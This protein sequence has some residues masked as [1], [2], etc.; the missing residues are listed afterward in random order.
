MRPY[1]MDLFG[2]TKYENDARKPSGRTVT[3]SPI[4]SLQRHMTVKEVIRNHAQSESIK[5]VTEF[6]SA[7][8]L[9]FC[10]H[11]LKCEFLTTVHQVDINRQTIETALPLIAFE[12]YRETRSTGRNPLTVNV[13][14]GNVGREDDRVLN[15]DVV[16]AI[17]L[18]EHLVSEDFEKFP[19]TVF[20]FI[21]PKLAIVTTPNYDFNVLFEN[22][23]AFR[24]HDHKFEFTRKQFEDWARD[25]TEKYRY[26]VEIFG[27]GEPPS[28]R[29][30]VG[31]CSQMAVFKK[32]TTTTP[33]T[34]KNVRNY[35]LIGSYQY[36]YITDTRT[37]E[38]KI[39]DAINSVIARYGREDYELDIEN[40]CEFHHRSTAL[41]LN[42]FTKH[43]QEW[44]PDE[45]SL[46]KFLENYRVHYPVRRIEAHGFIV[47]LTNDCETYG[48]YS[49]E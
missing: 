43:C 35:N 48:C 46:L 41:P 12:R 11:L 49:T 39:L 27:I 28:G 32:L 38:Q 19:S 20:G 24:H 1:P 40:E 8:F 26:S 6:G 14:E 5:T 17:E 4:L 37:T 29:E 31:Y 21:Q 23:V 47:I 42:L 34:Q 3:F 10:Q 30:D 18:I 9:F 33:T 25:I 7:H 16:V 44:C 22:G 13:F 15:S 45:S 36:F 2:L